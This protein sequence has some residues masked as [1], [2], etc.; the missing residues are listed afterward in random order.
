MHSHA[1]TCAKHAPND[2]I[3]TTMHQICMR[4]RSSG[5]KMFG[6]SACWVQPQWQCQGCCT[7]IHIKHT[8]AHSYHT[9]SINI[10]AHIHTHAVHVHTATHMH[11]CTHTYTHCMH[12]HTVTH[13]HAHTHWYNHTGTCACIPTSPGT[14]V[15]GTP[16][17][18]TTQ[19][20]GPGRSTQSRKMRFMT[21]HRTSESRGWGLV[22]KSRGHRG[23]TCCL[24]PRVDRGVKEFA[25]GKDAVSCVL[26]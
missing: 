20:S 17:W 26:Y 4:V 10:H 14:S 9:T 5:A 24:G 12:V 25:F 7:C 3:A 8:H 18:V 16:F 1:H 11:T 13:M 6:P 23:L 2:Q 15:Y 19:R 22:T 21:W